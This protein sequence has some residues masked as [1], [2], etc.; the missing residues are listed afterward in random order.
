MRVWPSIRLPA[1]HER[2]YSKYWYIEQNSISYEDVRVGHGAAQSD[3]QTMCC[4]AAQSD[5]QQNVE[6]CGCMRI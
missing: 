2:M 4:G 1:L 5:A 6:I 3:D